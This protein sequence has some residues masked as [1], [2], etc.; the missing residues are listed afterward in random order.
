MLLTGKRAA[1][2]MGLRYDLTASSPFYLLLFFCIRENLSI[3]YTNTFIFYVF[4][5][6]NAIVYSTHIQC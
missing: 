1:M 5:E 2:A 6:C 4:I 3:M